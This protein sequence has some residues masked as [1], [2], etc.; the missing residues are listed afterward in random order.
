[1]SIRK[2][3]L[4]SIL[5]TTV[6]LIVVLYVI[7][8]LIILNGFANVEAIMVKHD[9]KQVL[10]A[11]RSE[12]SSLSTAS[13]EWLKR[14]TTPEFIRNL[15][16]V[17]GE[18]SLVDE[19]LPDPSFDAILL[20]DSSAKPVFGILNGCKKNDKAKTLREFRGLFVA[21]PNL[22]RH[23][24]ASSAIIGIVLLSDG[25]FMFCSRP[26]MGGSPTR[27]VSGTLV[28]GQCID[29]EHAR[30]FS[31][32]LHMSI[33]FWNPKDPKT[34][35]VLGLLD[36]TQADPISVHSEGDDLVRGF[37]LLLDPFGQP[38]LIVEV[39]AGRNFYHVGLATANYF[40][41]CL[42]MVGIIFGAV[43]WQ[44]MEFG[45]LSRLTRLTKG[46]TDIAIRTSTLDRVALEGSDELSLLADEI[47]SMLIALER[48][49]QEI[50]KARDALEL[51]VEERTTQ[52]VEINEKLR[53]EI[54][55]RNRAQKELKSSEERYRAVVNIQTELICRFS[56]DWNLTFVNEAYCR[57]FGER[58]E[59]LIGK[60]A[61]RLKHERNC[62]LEDRHLILPSQ[63]QPVITYE[64]KILLDNGEERWQ[65]WSD[66]AI[67]DENGTIVE[68]QALGRDITELK[69]AEE[70]LKASAREK[71]VMLQEIHH[72]VKNNLQI[73]MSLLDLQSQYVHDERFLDVLKDAEHRILSIALVHEQLYQSENFAE[74]QAQQYVQDLVEDLL[75]ASETLED[76]V[77]LAI[78]VEDTAFGLAT[79]VPLGLLINELVTNSLKHAFPEER[80]GE[81]RILLKA[82]GE[83]AFELRIAD[84]GVG[85]PPGTDWR[86]RDSFGLYLVG[87]LV[88][89]LHGEMQ[90]DTTEGTEFLLRF[91]R[92]RER[93]KKSAHE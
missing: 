2:R 58:S 27:S 54:E 78:D 18:K 32:K 64:K 84:N 59:D 76:R 24:N 4:T 79:A 92:I 9:V 90:L 83:D 20:F 49:E 80:D 12:T 81:I 70:Q 63:D 87:S 48:S 77:T 74:I 23:K 66:Q 37:G 21:H 26:I 30:V 86:S 29:R 93:K 31:A 17:A 62:D 52:L 55:N 41:F 72:R 44:T 67:F 36:L 28:T 13:Q 61:Q 88:E 57:Y 33:I 85:L 16:K 19:S 40:L 22:L 10:S 68:F 53:E 82:I 38:S 51:R 3:V 47:N 7:S 73:M 11:L 34:A 46:V 89:Q 6:V 35:P 69:R 56:S 8:R 65:Q 60:P 71:E 1:M 43:I 91:K 25:P 42:V 14:N 45:I 5:V 50:I 39:R 75:Y 15:S